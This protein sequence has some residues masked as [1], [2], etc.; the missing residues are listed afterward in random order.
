MAT[1]CS[2]IETQKLAPMTRLSPSEMVEDFH[3]NTFQFACN[4]VTIAAGS[5]EEALL[6]ACEVVHAGKRVSQAQSQAPRRREP[7]TDVQAEAALGAEAAQETAPTP[8][9][10]SVSESVSESACETLVATTMKTPS[11]PISAD[12]ESPQYQAAPMAAESTSAPNQEVSLA[13]TLRIKRIPPKTEAPQHKAPESAPDLS[14]PVAQKKASMMQAEQPMAKVEFG[15]FEEE[16]FESYEPPAQ[17][18]TREEM[19]ELRDGPAAK[20]R[21]NKKRRQGF[22]GWLAAVFTS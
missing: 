13:D 1:A 10:E 16:F 9:I 8:A 22:W 17:P 18:L 5:I 14:E 7:R 2:S 21:P 3:L 15:S 20:Y 4:R 6:M 12:E 19:M 11:S